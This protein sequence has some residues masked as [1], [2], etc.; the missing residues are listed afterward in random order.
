MR[1]RPFLK[2]WLVVQFLLV[3]A[4]E[5]SDE[6]SVR[7]QKRNLG[8]S[9]VPAVE[10]G[11]RPLLF[12][13]SS[14]V[15]QSWDSGVP[16]ELLFL[17]GDEWPVKKILYYP[18]GMLFQEIDLID[19]SYGEAF[20]GSAH[21]AV[22][23][24]Y[25][26]GSIMRT[27]MLEK[28]LKEGSQRSFS[29]EGIL[30]EERQY[31]GNVLDGICVC[32]F[33]SGQIY[34]RQ[35]Y[36]NGV[37][38]GAHELFWEDGSKRY[39]ATYCRG[40]LNG[41]SLEWWNNGTVKLAC[42]W[43]NGL[44]HSGKGRH[45]FSLYTEHGKLIEQQDF[46][47][48]EPHGPHFRWHPNGLIA[49]TVQWVMGKKE[50]AKEY[51]DAFGIHIGHREFLH[52]L[53]VGKHWKTGSD[54]KRLMEA[55]F[56][57]P[58]CG[59]VSL[60]D[61]NGVQRFSYSLVNGK[62]SGEF[63]EFDGNK[64][65]RKQLF[66][67]Q[68]RL[69]GLQKGFHPQGG[70]QFSFEYVNGTR[71][72]L[73][74]EWFING[75]R[76]TRGFYVEGVPNGLFEFWYLNGNKRAQE[77]F[78]MGQAEG[79]FFYWHENGTRG[80]SETWAQGKKVDKAFV[81]NSL[82][83]LIRQEEWKEGLENGAWKE[84]DTFGK[85]KSECFFIQ[86][87][88]E[89]KDIEWNKQGLVT[90]LRFWKEGKLDGLAE[91]WYEDGT[92]CYKGSFVGGRQEGL[93]ERMYEREEGSSIQICRSEE[94]F[95]KG[96]LH[97]KQVA[98]YP[99]GTVKLESFYNNGILDGTKKSFND[100]GELIFSACYKRGHIEGEVFHKRLDGLEEVQCY[101]DNHPEGTWQLY[102]P[103]HP[104]FG[105]VKALEATFSNGLLQGEYL[106]Y[107]Q[108]G[109]LSFKVFYEQGMQEGSACIYSLDGRILMTAEFQKGELQG[110][111]RCFYPSGALQKEGMYVHDVLEG[112][113]KRFHENGL[114]AQVSFY[115]EGKL[116][117][118]VRSW[119]I[120]KQVIFEGEYKKGLRSGLF[121]K[122]DEKGRLRTT[123]KFEND[124]LV[125]RQEFSCD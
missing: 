57:S 66:Y 73:Q 62:V 68:D 94:R 107:N 4:I 105:R 24:F 51:Y 14:Q 81:W 46:I 111:F 78:K 112:E 37:R 75:Q 85:K 103:S 11:P 50:G 10:L 59:A 8:F 39:E 71:T 35:L 52:G 55:A 87:I 102:Y 44:L 54:E 89:G 45:A 108:T 29:E 31:H 76:E 25:E 82:G 33:P 72:G 98:Y 100:N 121:K 16:K 84:W 6:I 69:H 19:C 83:T 67:E 116:D 91:E 88:R 3:L 86:G 56:T 42:F 48:G 113:E 9:Q 118:L 93:H 26:N 120:K 64:K 36:K 110:A 106:E 124:V 97:G 60:F 115:K 119:N 32:Y 17:N 47:G 13:W 90:Q 18:S 101:R 23:S 40:V 63:L 5:S 15:V 70:I 58:G 22:W 28:G 99:N 43:M 53:P 80:C 109:Q 65:L 20:K 79:S 21:G 12:N 49:M 77:A 114:L 7:A 122:Y 38:S 104:T 125:D 30:V 27:E 123:Q 1:I 117:G 96:K 95:L 34:E 92:L 2:V 41:R 61:T 74:E